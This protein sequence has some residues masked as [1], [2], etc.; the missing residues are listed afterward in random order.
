MEAFGVLML[1]DV[2]VREVRGLAEGAIW[3]PEDRILFIDS[4]MSPPHRSQLADLLLA[5]AARDA[6]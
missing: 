5:D 1:L 2:R 6:S 3:L 4:E